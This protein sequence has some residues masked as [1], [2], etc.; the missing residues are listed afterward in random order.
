PNGVQRMSIAMENL[1]Q[2][3]S[4]LAIV[5]SDGNT[6]KVQCLL[7][8]S[9]DTEK[10]ELAGAIASVFEL[11]GADVELTGSYSGWNPNMKSPILHTMIESYEKLYGKR[12]SVTAIHAGL[13]C[14]IIGAKYPGM[15]MISFG[16]TIC[17]PHS[18][19]E[20][21]EIASVA[22]FYDFLCN[23]ISNAPKK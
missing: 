3:S 9:V 17:Y 16:P 8:S 14:G 11:A 21:V 7:R 19:D 13:E 12:P 2:T 20:K 10:G 4:N 22:K 18:P 6:I 23:T 1:V 15:D 5:A